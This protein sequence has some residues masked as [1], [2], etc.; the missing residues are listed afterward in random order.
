MH[1][2]SLKK[3]LC[4]LVQHRIMPRQASAWIPYSVML[5]RNITEQV[6]Y[7][8]WPLIY[9]ANNICLISFTTRNFLKSKHFFSLWTCYF[10]PK[11]KYFLTYLPQ[12]VNLSK[13]IISISFGGIN[14]LQIKKVK[15][16]LNA[17]ILSLKKLKEKGKI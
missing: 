9:A 16:Y 3:P 17:W 15:Q 14:L 2:D 1:P 11:I 4:G 10:D 7:S 5:K 12:A 8:S 6:I 13:I